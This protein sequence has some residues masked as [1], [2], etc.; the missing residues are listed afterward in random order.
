[1]K[2]ELWLITPLSAIIL[3]S[4]AMAVQPNQP[5]APLIGSSVGALAAGPLLNRR[6]Q[7]EKRYWQELRTSLTT[8]IQDTLATQGALV[9]EKLAQLQ[10]LLPDPQQPRLPKDRGRAAD[11]EQTLAL[12]ETLQNILEHH[13][14]E[15]A[16]IK[17]ALQSPSTRNC[18]EPKT[19][20]LYDI[21]NL[22]FLQGQRLT[23]ARVSELVAFE[24]IVATLKKTVDL[25]DILVQRAYGNWMNDILQHLTPQLEQLHIERVAVYGRNREQR[26]AADIQLAV[27]AIDI[28]HHHPE[29]NTFVL[30][31]GD[32]GF[33]SI[34][35]KLRD[36]GKRVIG[37]AYRGSASDSL[38]RVCHHF[39][40]LD[41][42][43]SQL[44]NSASNQTSTS[45]STGIQKQT[46]SIPISEM[47]YP[48]NAVPAL[49]KELEWAKIQELIDYYA[50]D[51]QKQED[52]NQGIAF[53]DFFN[54]LKR[55]IPQFDPLRFGFLKPSQLIAYMTENNQSPLCVAV[56]HSKAILCWRNKL[57]QDYIIH[58]YQPQEIHTVST[59][60]GIFANEL[61]SDPLLR[62]VGEWLIANRP[63]EMD[64][65][66]ANYMIAE[67]L[68]SE[69]P[70]VSRNGIR[71]ALSNYTR[72]NV[73][74]KTQNSNI[75][76]LNS[77]IE[78]FADLVRIT[79]NSFRQIIQQ[80][81]AALGEVIDEAVFLQAV[82]FAAD[83]SQQ[84]IGSGEVLPNGQ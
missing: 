9:T 67:Y 71:C 50:S 51:P 24:K 34:V 52:L 40:L 12:L 26:N 19:A 59:Y 57:P 55:I 64:M 16:L 1:M 54:D 69:Q 6:E 79:Q 25:G 43:F 14:S 18:K 10:T 81:L 70:Q 11:P 39:I 84:C 80:R 46:H 61:A 60:R 73:L 3:G 7:Q 27:D 83:F 76:C 29:I 33:G 28:V 4:A 75:I 20:I 72:A 38:Q 68:R 65:R 48:K 5:L 45:S 62:C 74:L 2:L 66:T 35:L 63:E 37:C 82:P 58:S 49:I 23:P 42:P 47:S 41:T 31:S 30:V 53:T 78:T 56:K 8:A 22:V 17:G 15:L 32:G 44:S 77:E 13:S 21:E 36:Y